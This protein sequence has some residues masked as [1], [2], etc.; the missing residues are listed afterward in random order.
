MAKKNRQRVAKKNVQRVEKRNRQKVEKLAKN[1]YIVLEDT[2][3]LSTYHYNYN[4]H[5][6]LFQCSVIKIWFFF[7]KIPEETEDIRSV[8]NRKRE[9]GERERESMRSAA[10]KECEFCG[11]P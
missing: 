11:A 9:K 10:A 1:Y 8:Y 6:P 4:T 2:K 3:D 7:T 5:H